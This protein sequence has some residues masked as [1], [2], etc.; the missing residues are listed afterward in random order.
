MTARIQPC[1]ITAGPDSGELAQDTVAAAISVETAIVNKDL[2]LL[3]PKGGNSA[4]TSGQRPAG[5][6]AVAKLSWHCGNSK[7]TSK[8]LEIDAV[9]RQKAIDWEIEKGLKRADH[10]RKL[11]QTV[12][13]QATSAHLFASQ[14]LELLEEFDSCPALLWLPD[15]VSEQPFTDLPGNRESLLSLA[16]QASHKNFAWE[17]PAKQQA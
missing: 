5:K 2:A 12:L 14:L 16:P 17:Q 10:Q 15:G 4:G 8:A 7:K 9:R 1:F 11:P 13:D 6:R 3:A